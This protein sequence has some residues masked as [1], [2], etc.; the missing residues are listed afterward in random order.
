MLMEGLEMKDAT[1]REG[2]SAGAIAKELA[3]TPAAVKKALAALKVDADFIKAG[4]AYYYSERMPKIK[5]A[6]G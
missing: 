1:G 6:L 3:T 5:A 2:L 4:C